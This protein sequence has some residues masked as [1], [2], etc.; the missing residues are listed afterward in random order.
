[1]VPSWNERQPSQDGGD[2]HN[3]D[4]GLLLSRSSSG[5][6]QDLVQVRVVV[7]NRLVE[8]LLADVNVLVTLTVTQHVVGPLEAH[9][10][11]SEHL[12]VVRLLIQLLCPALASL[13]PPG[14]DSPGHQ[15]NKDQLICT[16]YAHLMHTQCRQ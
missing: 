3:V 7:L 8:E 11:V 6:C 10:V 2:W 4:D 5:L 16:F 1:M 14:G 9:I 15:R 12:G 13:P